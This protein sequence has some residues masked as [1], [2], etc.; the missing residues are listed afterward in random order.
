MTLLRPLILFL[1]RLFYRFDASALETMRANG[2]T[3][4]VANHVSLLDGL[5]LMVALPFSATAVVNT[6]VARHP[7]YRRS[8][9]RADA[10]GGRPQAH[11]I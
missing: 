4:I 10:D 11:R 8:L 2:K 5:L 7:L 1:L 9:L 6:I 3:L